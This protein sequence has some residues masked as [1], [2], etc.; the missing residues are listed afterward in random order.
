MMHGKMYFIS[1]IYS[2]II[3]LTKDLSYYCEIWVGDLSTLYWCKIIAPM[4]VFQG[5]VSG[6]TGR[7][8]MILDRNQ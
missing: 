2:F 3:E 5:D 1:L 4:F 8:I 6:Y 7:A